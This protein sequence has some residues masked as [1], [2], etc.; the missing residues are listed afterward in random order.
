L[1]TLYRPDGN[2]SIPWS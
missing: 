1:A 2:G